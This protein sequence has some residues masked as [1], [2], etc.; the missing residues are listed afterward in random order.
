MATGQKIRLALSLILHSQHP[1]TALQPLYH[2][3]PLHTVSHNRPMIDH[4]GA[5]IIYDLMC[6]L[7]R[8]V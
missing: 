7:L 6:V 1:L 2:S 8:G 4:A 5:G 3:A